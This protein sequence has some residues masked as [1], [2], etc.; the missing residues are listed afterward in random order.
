M[1]REAEPRNGLEHYTLR[2]VVNDLKDVENRFVANIQ[3]LADSADARYHHNRAGSEAVFREQILGRIAQS[4]NNRKDRLELYFKILELMRKFW[5]FRS[6]YWFTWNDNTKDVKLVATAHRSNKPKFLDLPVGTIDQSISEVNC[7]P[8][9]YRREG[10]VQTTKGGPKSLEQLLI[11][12]FQWF[13]RP[14]KGEPI[15]NEWIES[16]HDLYEGVSHEHIPELD[17]EGPSSHFFVFV[18]HGKAIHALVFAER[19]ESQVSPLRPADKG[20][21]SPIC[22]HAIA[23]T[24]DSVVRAYL[25]REDLDLLQWQQEALTIGAIG[26]TLVH[27]LVH[28]LT[29]ARDYGD[30]C[31]Q[32]LTQ[33]D[34]A[35]AKKYMD[36]NR[37]AIRNNIELTRLVEV[38]RERKKPHLSPTRLLPFLDKC[39]KDAL[40]TNK[41]IDPGAP[42][43]DDLEIL[44]D[45]LL[46]K[47]AINNIFKNVEKKALNIKQLVV[48]VH[49]IEAKTA[50]VTIEDNG[51]GFPSELLSEFDALFNDGILTSSNKC[52][53]LG[54][55]IVR[56]VMQLHGGRLHLGNVAKKGGSGGRVELYFPQ[57]N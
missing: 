7:P 43:G 21:I 13:Y 48:T 46:L 44:V 47:V 17:N 39:I 42:I 52:L 41:E 24:C 18:K 14:T 2:F 22:Q 55:V 20:N 29:T 54:F 8:W 31:S 25:A 57:V 11:K 6:I 40:L 38:F 19:D 15:S 33:G 50:L 35:S 49:Q 51:V 10:K 36:V 27:D 12:N 45:P 53:G 23:D 26:T 5:A 37:E 3:R 1:R 9:L 16:F 32:E 4:G 34:V 56:A 30:Y 28:N